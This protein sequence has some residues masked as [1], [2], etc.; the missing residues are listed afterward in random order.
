VTLKENFAPEQFFTLTNSEKLS[1]H[2][3]ETMDSGFKIKG[4]SAVVMPLGVSKSVDYELSYL[5]KKKHSIVFAGLYKFG[6]KYFRRSMRASAVYQSELS[7]MKNKISAIAAEPVKVNPP[8][9]AI[10]STADLKLHGPEH[11]AGSYAEAKVMLN[12]LLENNPT[13]Y[14]KIQVVAGYEL[15]KN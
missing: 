13:L 1:R 7:S 5:K 9:Y 11:V 8:Q 12:E 10:A 6:K 15:N 3:F 2:S 4:N 14:N